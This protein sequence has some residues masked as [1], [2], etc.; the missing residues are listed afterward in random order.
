[1]PT[2]F[3]VRDEYA[4]AR[5]SPVQ[6][7]QL[8]PIAQTGPERFKDMPDVPTLKEAGI[9]VEA[10]T[11]NMIFVPAGTPEDIQKKLVETIQKVFS[12]P[13]GHR[14]GRKA[15]PA[16]HQWRP[17]GGDGPARARDPALGRGDQEYE[18]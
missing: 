1:V 12:N 18:A 7:G 16:S 8:R 9:D 11:S 10:A 5:P 3:L 6:S 13:R 2:R 15:R 14:Q 17:G 4:W